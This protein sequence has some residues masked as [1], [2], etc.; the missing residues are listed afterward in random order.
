MKLKVAV[1]NVEWMSHLFD[2]N[3]NPKASG[4]EAARAAQ[5][6]KV[7]AK[8]SPDILGI[9]EGPD[10]TVSGSKSASQQLEKWAA[11]QGLHASFKGVHGF[12]SNGQQELCALY[13]SDKV[14]VKFKPEKKQSKHPFN[15]QFLVDTSDTLIK[16][17]YKHYRAPLEL[18]VLSLT[19]PAKE[20]ARV[21]VAHTKSKG[22]FDNVDIARFEQLSERNRKKLYA[23]CLS[24]RER[25]DQWLTDE[26]KRNVVVMGD[27]ND[28][29]GMDYY[30][31]RFSR[32]A[33][34]LL[35]GD[36]WQ[37]DIQMKHVLPKPKIDSKGWVPY[38]SDFR[39]AL[40]E[41]KVNVLIDHMLVSRNVKVSDATVW[42]PH[43]K[44]NSGIAAIQSVKTELDKASDHYPVM[45]TL[46]MTPIST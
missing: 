30:E 12:P 36:P 5:L 2:S 44:A 8:M 9:V 40:T 42:N 27:I 4:A 21:I 41:F 22:I 17:A 39:D 29:A 1:Y 35:M 16:E 3:G 7:V 15:E 33:V 6:G 14:N 32:S 20:V 37:P 13:R 38:S 19:S 10:T 26:P 45:A 23:E 24:V 43:L 31:R 11:G 25:C 28:G 34:E 18:Q 46:E